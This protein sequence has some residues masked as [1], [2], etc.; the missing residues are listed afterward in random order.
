MSVSPVVPTPAPIP[1]DDGQELPSTSTTGPTALVAYIQDRSGSMRGVW[2]EN[3]S[4][5]DTFVKELKEKNTAGV[6]YLLSLVMFD[7]QID[8]PL[9]A[10]PIAEV[11][12]KDM[13]P[14]EPRGSTSLRDAVGFTIKEIE[15]HSH[16]ASSI[17][18]VVATDGQENASKEWTQEGLSALIQEKTNASWVFT[19]MGSEASSWDDSNSVGYATGNTLGYTPGMSSQRNAVLASAVMSFASETNANSRLHAARGDFYGKDRLGFTSPDVEVNEREYKNLMKS[20]GLTIK[21]DPK[22]KDNVADTSA[23]PAPISQPN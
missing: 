17:I 3:L 6:N 2:K 8:N 1:F 12:S 11:S 18:V 9:V 19:Y 22:E 14:F 16:G 21:E 15:A 20:A 23:T 7:T 5:F 10:K 4:G 13:E